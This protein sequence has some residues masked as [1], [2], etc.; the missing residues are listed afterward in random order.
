MVSMSLQVSSLP[1]C[2]AELQEK[3]EAAPRAARSPERSP[4]IQPGSHASRS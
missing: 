3:L 2:E 1:S 4:M